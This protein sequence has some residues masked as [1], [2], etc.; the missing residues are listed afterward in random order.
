MRYFFLLFIFLFSMDAS[1]QKHVYDYSP[2]T[3]PSVND[4]EY[5]ID[6]SDLT[7]GPYGTGKNATIR[8][9]FLAANMGVDGTNVGIGSLLPGTALDVAGNIRSTTGGYIFPDGTTQVSA[10]SSTPPAGS[11]RE[12]QFKSGSSFGAVSGSAVDSN[13]NVGIGSSAPGAALDVQGAVRVTGSGDSIFSSNIGVGTTSTTH[14]L[15]VVGTVSATSYLGD[16]SSLTGITA[17]GWSRNGSALSPTTITDVVGIGTTNPAAI[18]SNYRFGLYDASANG[19]RSIFVY[20]PNTGTSAQARYELKTSDSNGEL[21][22]FPTNYTTSTWA[23]RMLLYGE[24]GNGTGIAAANGLNVTFLNSTTERMRLDSTGNFGIGTSAPNSL[25]EVGVS[26]FNVLSGGN[27][28]IGSIVPRQKLDVQGSVQA[29][30]FIGDGSGL[31]GISGGAVGVGTVNSGTTG[32]TAYYAGNGNTLTATSNLMISG[33]N[34]GVGTALPA[35]KFEVNGS[36]SGTTLTTASGASMGIINTDTTNNNFVDYAFSTTDSGGS[37]ILGSKISGIFKSHT[38]A[39]VSGEMAFITKNAGT[40][41][42][43]M[44]LSS[45]GNLGI[46][47]LSPG[48]ALDVVGTV[49]ATAFVGDGSGITGISGGGGS[50]TINSG[51]I[52]RTAY[53]TGATTVS[54]GNNFNN[55]TNIGLGTTNNTNLLDVA[56]GV[57]V[58]TT[59]AGY[60][61]APTEGMI[62]QGNLGIGTYAPSLGLLTVGSSFPFVVDSTGTI[63]R[64]NGT[65]VTVSGSNIQFST[66]SAMTVANS[67]N[68]ASTSLVLRGGANAASHLDITSTTGTGTSDY[69]RI[70]TGS[71]NERFRIDT[72]GNVGI[73]TT[74][75]LAPLSF[76]GHMHSHGGSA[77][78]AGTCGTSP[79]ITSK[80]TDFSGSITVGTGASTTSC[81][82]TFGTAFLNAPNCIVADDTNVLAVSPSTTTSALTVA[83][84]SSMSSVGSGDKI[85]WICIGNE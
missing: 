49:R 4:L 22:N 69:V 34:V 83:S 68:G 62:I 44:R 72:S 30:S 15:D 16:G 76:V 65:G 6:T 66:N 60:R 13:G 70:L 32:Q 17:V 46:G 25:L 85:S 51:T 7:D 27:V 56:G 9:H 59:Y 38:A 47:S 28:G 63:I 20:N 67:S 58:G 10:A 3:A 45:A 61:T 81:V 57:S 48:T 40:T 82:V 11:A 73:G 14:A 64:L 43:R 1:A 77:P 19:A 41:A 36:D 35:R 39:A 74:V 53:Y 42:E 71:S 21:I 54:S 24:T 55:G 26:K 33:S 75:P 12:L 29:T 80:S 23:G 37:Q 79:S 8:Q 84:L 50:G 2:N 18:N 31:T 5:T 52:N 78:T